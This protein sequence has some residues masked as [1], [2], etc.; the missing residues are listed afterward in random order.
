MNDWKS[1]PRLFRWPFVKAFAGSEFVK[2]AA[3]VPVFGYLIL[4]NDDV[5]GALNFSKIAGVEESEPSP[6]IFSSVTKL[7]LA[8]F[9]GLCMLFANSLQAWLSPRVLLG[10][11]NDFEFA[12]RVVST[13]SFGEIVAIQEEVLSSNWVWRTP[14]MQ[15]LNRA[16]KDRRMP[17]PPF[18]GMANKMYIVRDHGDYLRGICREWWVGQMHK[19]RVWRYLILLIAS[20]GYF[21][22]LLPT[23]DITQAV[24]IDL[25]N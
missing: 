9:G 6:F 17:H 25:F 12:E 13:Y 22:L 15:N 18:S 21:M 23:L 5:V 10:S 20:A 24:A 19:S 8:F 1:E 3:A 2:F 16:A 7:R 11:S 4:F 14:I